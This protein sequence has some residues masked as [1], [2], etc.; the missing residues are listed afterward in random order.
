MSISLGTGNAAMPRQSDVN[1]RSGRACSLQTQSQLILGVGRHRLRDRGGKQ[2][3]IVFG[4]HLSSCALES[5]NY[6]ARD[7]DVPCAYLQLLPRLHLP[8]SKNEHWRVL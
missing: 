5:S 8:F 6:E 7:S 4:V 1:A 3:C 2:V